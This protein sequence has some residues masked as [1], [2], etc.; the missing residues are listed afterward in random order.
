MSAERVYV[1]DRREGK[2]V[3]LVDDDERTIDVAASLLPKGCRAEGAV[4]RVPVGRDGTPE[5]GSAKRDQD[6][7]RR[8]AA[9]AAE[10]IR[11]LAKNDAGGDVQL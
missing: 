3:V 9:D 5:W 10:R 7:E 8:R 2:V 6:E 4:L 1:V 11:K